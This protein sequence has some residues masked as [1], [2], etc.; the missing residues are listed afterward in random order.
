M[1]A[2]F[3]ID[4]VLVK[5]DIVPYEQYVRV[6]RGMGRGFSDHHAI[7]CKVRLV[8]AWIKR[9]EEKVGGLGVRN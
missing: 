2:K 3:L 5:K 7:L 6:V 1:K 8:S 9:R 4:L